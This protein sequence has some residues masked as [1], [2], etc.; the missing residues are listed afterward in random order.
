MQTELHEDHAE[1]SGEIYEIQAIL[2]I[3]PNKSRWVSVG[4]SF[5]EK[6]G[7]LFVKTD[8]DFVESL[9]VTERIGGR[10]MMSGP[11]FR[12][13]ED[14]QV[15]LDVVRE[16]GWVHGKRT[17]IVLR[18]WHESVTAMPEKEDKE[19][20]ALEQRV[21]ELEATVERLQRKF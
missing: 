7:K 13:L 8:E 10:F 17:R 2:A 11:A 4:W 3:N 15:F 1:L 9:V 21:A 16:E 14:A 18:K 6:D 19:R 12:T 5:F 20:M